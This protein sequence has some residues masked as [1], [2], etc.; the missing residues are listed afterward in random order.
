MKTLKEIQTW[1]KAKLAESSI[2]PAE[3][4]EMA[5]EVVDAEG[6][7]KINKTLY[8][9]GILIPYFDVDG[10]QR[11]DT[12][13]IRYAPGASGFKYSQPEN[14]MVAAYF[15]P[16]PMIKKHVKRTWREIIEDPSIPIYITEGEFKSACGVIHGLPVIGLGGVSSIS[17]K[18]KGIDF[19][20]ELE[21]ITWSGRTVY[22]VYDSDIIIKPEVQ[23]ALVMLCSKLHDR[24]ATPMIIRLPGTSIY[25]KLKKAGLDDF[26]VAMGR[27]KFDELVKAAEIFA[28]ARVF[29]EL[30]ERFAYY[31]SL[32][33]C[34]DFQ[35]DDKSVDYE[36]VPSSVM[37][38]GNRVP[39]TIRGPRGGVGTPV[40]RLWMSW[41]NRRSIAK[42][43]YL[44]GEAR[45]VDDVYNTWPGWGIEPERGDVKPILELLKHLIPQDDRRKWF[46]QWLAYPLRFPGTR[47]YSAAA[48]WGPQG[49]GKSFVGL[50]MCDIYGENAKEISTED[51]SGNFNEWAKDR[52]F[53]LVDEAATSKHAVRTTTSAMKRLITQE[54]ITVNE[55]YARK[56]TIEA[57]I[58]YYFTSNH[59]TCLALDNNDRRYFV[60]RVTATPK[61]RGFYERANHWRHEKN[62][63]SHFFYY[64]LHDVDLEG[65]DY[66]AHAF[67]TEDKQEMINLTVQTSAEVHLQELEKTGGLG[68]CDL[69]T[70]KD[71]Q[72][73]YRNKYPNTMQP[74]NLRTYTLALAEYPKL[75][76]KITGV[77]QRPEH[78]TLY[79]ITNK[80]KW[81][82]LLSKPA[83]WGKEY[84]AGLQRKNQKAKQEVNF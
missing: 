55:K 81:A 15:A 47:L 84:A 26:L 60:H 20:P 43:D 4:K 72:D 74:D 10:K 22:V 35:P 63:P 33:V 75:T 1:A 49:V 68:W 67:L 27:V 41:P 17:S 62:G 21:E 29:H 71:L 77:G 25:G 38:Y 8:Y 65:F 82:A 12:V 3:I 69:A 13:R 51:L 48:L 45:Y 31:A 18:K 24:G 78:K 52:Q 54:T 14:S 73:D 79:A 34:V 61:D 19:L 40:T 76:A 53:V 36:L 59:P 57:C 30:N 66:R 42:L 9:G 23:L 6:A 64:L 56:R 5:L 39:L 11:L 28:E 80:E 44:P 37:Y 50:V 16:A 46:L 58:N 2:G 83:L 70:V 32:D 7:Q